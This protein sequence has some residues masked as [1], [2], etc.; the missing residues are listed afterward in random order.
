MVLSAPVKISL[1]VQGRWGKEKVHS[2]LARTHMHTHTH[3]HTHTHIHTQTEQIHILVN[4]P[5]DRKTKLAA[6]AV[7]F[8]G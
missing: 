3:T 4:A 8:L 5:E 1:A 7:T 2:T 6:V